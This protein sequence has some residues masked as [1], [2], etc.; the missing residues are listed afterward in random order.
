M[1][2]SKECLVA[3]RPLKIETGKLAN[4]ADSSVTVHYGDTVVLVTS[5]VGGVGQNIV[6]FVRLTVDYEERHYAVGKIPGS[7][8]RREARPSENA[9]LTARLTDR[10]LRPLLSKGLNNEVQ[11]VITV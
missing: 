3:D 4:Q 7:F 1:I 9:T 8:T 11:I 5:W 2:H 10:H 6:D